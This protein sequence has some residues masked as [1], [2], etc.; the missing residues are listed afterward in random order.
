MTGDVLKQFLVQLGFG[1][2]EKGLKTFTSAVKEATLKVTV[3]ATAV[4]ALAAGTFLGISKISEG[5]EEF[6]YST[7]MIAPAINKAI[8]LRKAMTAAYKEAGINM[9]QAVQQSIKFNFSLA[10]TKF[11]LEGIVKST[12]LKF[13]PMLTKQMD[14]FRTKVSANLPKILS[15][16]ERFVK[17]IFKAFEGTILFTSRVASVLSRIWEMLVKLDDATGGWSTKILALVAAWNF[18]NLSFL[19]TPLGMLLVGLLAILALYDDFMTWK[20]GGES[21]FDWADPAIKLVVG[22]TSSIVALFAAF[23][24]GVAT[25]A[26]IK[27]GIAGLTFAF[28]ALKFATTAAGLAFNMTP[29]GKLVTIVGLL[30]AG[31]TL[32]ITKWD[33]VKEGFTS[34]FSGIGGKILDF[35]GGET[36][37][38]KNINVQPLGSSTQQGATQS[39]SQ[40]TNIIVQGATDPNSVAKKIANEQNNVNFNMVRNLKGA[41]R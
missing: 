27:A 11:Q 2:D 16:L 9:V 32:L 23:K 28:S 3:M 31:L 35:V 22:V 17:F 40:E 26:L 33:A 12:A 10:K 25:V 15:F 19:R 39:V 7:R 8:L 37:M 20:E 14:I 1:V 36:E 30:V 6:G 29:I 34:F 4:K 38:N 21:L 24:A 13:L 5:F 18:L 41:T